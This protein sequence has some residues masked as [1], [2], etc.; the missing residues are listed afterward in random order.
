[1]D[2]W[3]EGVSREERVQYQ[4]KTTDRYNTRTQEYSN[5]NIDMHREGVCVRN[6]SDDY[7]YEQ[8]HESL[9]S[10]RTQ[11]SLQST[12]DGLLQCRVS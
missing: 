11:D 6:D 9:T 10:V 4:D 8:I 1:M 7:D 2:G 3:G 5:S 12:G